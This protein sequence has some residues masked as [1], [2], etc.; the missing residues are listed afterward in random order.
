MINRDTVTSHY[1]RTLNSL[2]NIKFMKKNKIKVRLCSSHITDKGKDLKK[3]AE[4]PQYLQI[5][6]LPVVLLAKL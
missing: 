5:I 3:M 4:A 2:S 6:T 1:S